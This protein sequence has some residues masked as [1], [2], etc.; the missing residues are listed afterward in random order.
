M[1]SGTSVAAAEVSGI[2]ALMLE[3]APTLSPDDVRMILMETAKHLGNKGRNPEF[4][5]GLVDAA[6]AVETAPNWS[7]PAAIR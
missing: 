4:G 2:V 3:R 1:T 7:R 6:R 5:A